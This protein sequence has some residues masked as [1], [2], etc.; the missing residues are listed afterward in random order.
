MGRRSRK[1]LKWPSVRRGEDYKQHVR[2]AARGGVEH[3]PGCPQ[4]Y[5]TR[6]GVLRRIAIITFHDSSFQSSPNHLST[7]LI[8]CLTERG[9]Y[10]FNSRQMQRIG[11]VLNAPPSDQ[12]RD[13]LRKSRT[14][15]AHT[16]LWLTANASEKDLTRRARDQRT[17]AP[18]NWLAP[19][20]PWFLQPTL[21]NRGPCWKFLQ[22]LDPSRR[23]KL[24]LMKVSPSREK[25]DRPPAEFRFSQ[26]QWE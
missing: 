13:R 19:N 4:L 24:W 16:A 2:R 22:L 9:I 10:L 23:N 7:R 25:P 1:Q 11:L 21:A 18:S 26:S 20:L 6:R 12:S 5:Y 14:R 17:R 3:A 15:S 8:I